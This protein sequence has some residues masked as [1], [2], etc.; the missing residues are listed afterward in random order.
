MAE[1]N[2]LLNRRMGKT[3]P[4]VRIPASPH[5]KKRCYDCNFKRFLN[6]LFSQVHSNVLFTTHVWTLFR[7]FFKI[8]KSHASN[9]NKNVQ[10]KS[11][12]NIIGPF[13]QDVSVSQITSIPS[14]IITYNI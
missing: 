5:R 9:V 7:H 8:T 12:W 4:R 13:D 6:F 1:T 2:G 11:G 3:V 10:V 14:D